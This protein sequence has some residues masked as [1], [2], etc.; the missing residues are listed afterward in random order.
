MAERQ[1]G[2]GFVEHTFRVAV[3]GVGNLYARSWVSEH[4]IF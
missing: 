3:L 4:E 1:F 2:T